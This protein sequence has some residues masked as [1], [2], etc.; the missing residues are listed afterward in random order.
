MQVPLCEKCRQPDA[1]RRIYYYPNPAPCDTCGRPV[2]RR[3]SNR[4]PPRYY[5]CSGVCREAAR[6]TER[7][8]AVC[9]WA[10]GGYPPGART[11]GPAC[12][13]KAHRGRVTGAVFVRWKRRV[14][15]DH[16]HGRGE[17]TGK[18]FLLCAALVR[19]ERRDGKTRQRFVAYLGSVREEFAA[20][21]VTARAR[22]W[23]QVG[24]RLDLLGLDARSRRK[25]EDGIRQRVPP[26]PPGRRRR[27][28][29]GTPRSC[30]R[31]YGG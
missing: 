12:A 13:K 26:R 2:Y 29:A 27:T 16:W 23:D 31:F 5:V 7:K 19:S 28:H 4:R 21:S 25:V 9:G 6:R 30:R 3:Y 24:Q 20:D 8:C 1:Y 18:R 14:R 22:F 17:K 11:C 15:S 10:F